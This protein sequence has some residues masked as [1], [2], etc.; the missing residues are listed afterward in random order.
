VCQPN[1]LLVQTFGSLADFGAFVL[2]SNLT[3]SSSPAV[4]MTNADIESRLA[5]RGGVRLTRSVVNHPP[6]CTP[7]ASSPT[8][9]GVVVQGPGVVDMP[10]TGIECG[11]L[12]TST[13]VQIV[14]LPSF[15]SPSG[16][17]VVR[18]TSP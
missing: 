13:D 7:T 18:T 15:G 17:Y 11:S 9:Y 6:V 16:S 5:V 12:L 2:G 3:P 8:S 10:S 14:T 1:E 4:E